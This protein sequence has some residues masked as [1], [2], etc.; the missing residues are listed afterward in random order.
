MISCAGDYC[1]YKLEGHCAGSQQ[2]LARA[3]AAQ[4]Q[5]CSVSKLG[6]DSKLVFLKWATA[7][8]KGA[9]RRA[10]G[11]RPDPVRARHAARPGAPAAPSAA[12]F[13]ATARCSLLESAREPR[14]ISHHIL[15][16]ATPIF[17]PLLHQ[18]EDDA[19]AGPSLNTSGQATEPWESPMHGFLRGFVQTLTPRVAQGYTR[20]PFL[21]D[22]G[23]TFRCRTPAA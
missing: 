20:R 2:A 22:G 4:R 23:P 19:H 17:P 9:R 5:L 11:A 21:S 8:V 7:R 3:C 18:T 15:N 10:A 14:S 13:D 12:V 16:A 1:D 6:H